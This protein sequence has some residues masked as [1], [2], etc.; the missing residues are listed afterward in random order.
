MILSI[1]RVSM[2]MVVFPEL[3]RVHLAETFVAL[4]VDL[5]SSLAFYVVQQFPPGRQ[6]LAAVILR[7]DERRL[8]PFRRL[9][10]HHAEA[11]VFGLRG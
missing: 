8:V 9:A 7:G 6:C 10:R 3:L 2:F 5:A 11:A 1:V 4:H